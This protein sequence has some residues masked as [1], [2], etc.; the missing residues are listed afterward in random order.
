VNLAVVSVRRNLSSALSPQIKSLNFLNNI[1]A[2]QDAAKHG[3]FDGVM[4]NYEGHV[5]ECTTSNILFAK[6]QRL[7]T[8][9]VECGILDGVTREIV[10][11]LAKEEKLPIEEG[12]YTP[13]ILQDA[14]ECFLTNTTMEIMPVRRIDA[15]QI[16]D[17]IPGPITRRLQELFRINLPRFLE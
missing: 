12:C 13:E 15:Q 11:S 3:A 10:L 1:L 7:Y 9:S 16:G 17:E 14:D 8:P 2:K 6:D 4:L 5:T